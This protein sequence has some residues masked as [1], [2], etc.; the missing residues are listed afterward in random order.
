ME[1]AFVTPVSKK[2]RNRFIN[3]MN[4]N[5]ECIVRQYKENKVFLESINHKHSFWV[6]IKKDSD[7]IVEF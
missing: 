1:T 7:W 5:D 4:Q 6:N 2:A 3:L